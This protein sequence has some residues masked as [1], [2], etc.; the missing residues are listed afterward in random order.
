MGRR[1]YENY[2]KRQAQDQRGNVLGFF[3]AFE[4]LLCF[5]LAC[6]FGKTPLERL[7]TEWQWTTRIIWSALIVT[8]I[9][10]SYVRIFGW[11]SIDLS[12]CIVLLIQSSAAACICIETGT[13]ATQTVSMK[14]WLKLILVLF[15]Y[16][17]IGVML[18]HPTRTNRAQAQ[19]RWRQLLVLYAYPPL[20]FS[21]V[22]AFTLWYFNTET[23]NGLML[24]LPM[25]VLA[26]LELS[27][28]L[29]IGDAIPSGARQTR[30]LWLRNKRRGAKTSSGARPCRLQARGGG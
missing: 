23:T 4:V 16:L 30:R 7:P 12:S 17:A 22:Y 24:L 1:M 29:L 26:I 20:V 6:L 2:I 21:A 9:L 14:I 27:S 19:Q 10:W 28:G 3:F 13:I 15:G 8:A 25:V 18:V 5:L 11:P